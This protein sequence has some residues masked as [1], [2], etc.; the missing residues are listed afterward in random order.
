MNPDEKYF[1]CPKLQNSIGYPEGFTVADLRNED[2][3]GE[4]A[5]D[6]WREDHDCDINNVD[7]QCCEISFMHERCYHLCFLWKL[8]RYFLPTLY[9]VYNDLQHARKGTQRKLTDLE[10]RFKK[11]K[12]KADIDPEE[13][14]LGNTIYEYFA[15]DH[16]K[17]H[18]S[19]EEQKTYGGCTG[20]GCCE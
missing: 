19:A 16:Y 17:K 2:Y 4:R 10:K 6:R 14:E 15:D 3:E 7:V 8:Y 18:L 5:G 12:I 11:N 20:R 13:I 9:Y 1:I